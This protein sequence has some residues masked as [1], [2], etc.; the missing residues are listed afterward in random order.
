MQH[1]AFRVP[2]WTKTFLLQQ[3][4]LCGETSARID[5][6]SRYAKFCKGLKT[7]ISQEVRVL[8]NLVARDLQTTTAKNIRFVQEESETEMW[9]VCPTKLKQALQSKST[10]E[11][12]GHDGWKVN[13]LATLLYQ[14]RDASVL[15][16]E[17]RMNIL[18]ELIDSLVR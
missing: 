7:S 14:L 16:Q 11:I 3:V 9:T 15:V 18:Q 5:I 13:Y 10:V 6:L 8:F 2:R 12:P 1:A 4:L 17:D